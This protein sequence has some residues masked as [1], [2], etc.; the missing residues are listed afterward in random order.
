MNPEPLGGD[1][2]RQEKNDV[3]P[4]SQYPDS[5]AQEEIVIQSPPA[6][7]AQACTEVLGQLVEITTVDRTTGRIAG[8]WASSWAWLNRIRGSIEVRVSLDGNVTNLSISARQAENAFTNGR[9]AQDM[10]ARFLRGL[11]QHPRILGKTTLGW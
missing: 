6:V 3:Y 10:V 9:G 11:Q 5:L 1:V 2:A 4:E 7:I 8:R